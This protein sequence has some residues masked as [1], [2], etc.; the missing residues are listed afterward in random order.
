MSDEWSEKPIHER[1]KDVACD[2]IFTDSFR[3]S[4]LQV[5]KIFNQLKKSLQKNEIELKTIFIK[6]YKCQEQIEINAE[7]CGKIANEN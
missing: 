7:C 4:G 1:L 6:C 5:L 3:P 2:Q